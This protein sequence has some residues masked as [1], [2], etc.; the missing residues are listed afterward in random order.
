M[1]KP[2]AGET[3]KDF[4]SRCIPE[5]MA[6]GTEQKQAIAMCYSMYKTKEAISVDKELKEEQKE[7]IEEKKCYDVE[8]GPTTW[9][10]SFAEYDSGEE[11]KEAV[12]EIQETGALFIQM[13]KNIMFGYDIVDRVAAVNSLTEEYRMRIESLMQDGG[14]KEAKEEAKEDTED[15]KVALKQLKEW[16][17]EIKSFFVG[18]KNL[19]VYQS[20]LTLTKGADGKPWILLWSTNSFVDR[21]DEIFTT[22]S[23]DDFIERH[24]QEDIK[25]EVWFCHFP[26]SKFA[27][28]KMQT[29]VGRFLLEAA[30]FDDTEMGQTFEKFFQDYPTGHP[31][32]APN[33]WGQSHGY[34]FMRKDRVDGIYTA[35]E[36]YE[37]TILPFDIAAN[38]HNPRPMFTTEDN[39]M[40]E[41]QREAFEGVFGK[42][43]VEQMVAEGETKTAE[44]EATGVAYKALDVVDETVEE[45]V[46]EPVIEEKQAEEVAVEEVAEEIVVED[47][48]IITTVE[49]TEIVAPVSR[50]EITEGLKV[51]AEEMSKQFEI[52]V[53]EKVSAAVDELID[54]IVPLAKQ[55]K[56][57]TETDE[58]KIVKS[59]SDTPASS[60]AA[61]IQSSIIG[62]KETQVD[63]RTTLAKDGPEE[64]ETKSD[65]NGPNVAG[66]SL[67]LW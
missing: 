15:D 40:N 20:G 43:I 35:F 11:A 47:K 56:A 7:E 29:R 16:I 58:Q 14:I 32:I 8:E 64:T 28:I 27:N 59:V 22:K 50:E 12:E 21:D 30:P 61:M 38:Q 34:T 48:E 52:M 65:K 3:E 49:E 4:V 46:T 55:V 42:S 24:E 25:G 37:S 66:V 9:A 62:A 31:V 57:M 67:N 44:L 41:K 26:G 54:V 10:T 1:P 18:K 53:A 23:I 17:S 45:V 51:L 60:L 5:V 2:T 19:D 13:V 39:L 36:K 33:G 6:E 63:G